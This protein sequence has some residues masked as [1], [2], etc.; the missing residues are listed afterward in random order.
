MTEF[1]YTDRYEAI[2]C[3]YPDV[4]TMCKGHCDGTGVFPLHRDDPDLELAGLW[5]E[6]HEKAHT[7][8][9]IIGVTWHFIKARHWRIVWDC[10]TTPEFKCDGWHFVRCPDCKGTGVRDDTV[11]QD[12]DMERTEE[13]G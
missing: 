7:W 9:A 4:N 11:R 8:K 13:T 1:E 12:T 5:E 2:G 10:I 6:A 3:G